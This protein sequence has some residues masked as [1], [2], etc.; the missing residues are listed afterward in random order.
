[1]KKFLKNFLI[2]ALIFFVLML[3]LPTNIWFASIGLFIL[4]LLISSYIKNII[5]YKNGEKLPEYINWI[6][7]LAASAMSEEKS[8]HTHYTTVSTAVD[9]TNDLEKNKQS[10][11]PIIIY[12]FIIIALISFVVFVFFDFLRNFSTLL[13]SIS[14]LSI[15]FALL[16]LFINYI[17]NIMKKMSK[18]E[19]I[20]KIIIIIAIIMGILV[21]GTL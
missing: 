8:F 10:K 19:S 2:I 18:K 6:L 15:V 5:K 7:I 12:T 1:M 3:I 11:I 16:I 20:M 17:C 4:Y 21:M 13:L 9:A 14:F